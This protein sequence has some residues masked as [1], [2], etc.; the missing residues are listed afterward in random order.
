[1]SLNKSTTCVCKTKG[2]VLS[3][4]LPILVHFEHNKLTS[5]QKSNIHMESI[6]SLSILVCT[7][8]SL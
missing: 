4:S 8:S 5:F 6:L 7:H 1:M 3:Y 2:T